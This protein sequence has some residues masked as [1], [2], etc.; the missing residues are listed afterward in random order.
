MLT[1][2]ACTLPTC[3]TS[4]HLPSVEFF[5]PPPGLKTLYLEKFNEKVSLYKMIPSTVESLTLNFYTSPVLLREILSVAK[6]TE[7][8]LPSSFEGKNDLMLP[9][10][11]QTLFIGIKNIPLPLQN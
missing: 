3:L 6:L 2:L 8:H 7:L 11:L 10:T 4:L 5:K 1:E 9:S